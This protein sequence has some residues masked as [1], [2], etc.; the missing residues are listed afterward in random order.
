MR[1][2]TNNDN[3]KKQRRQLLIDG[4]EVKLME[5]MKVEEYHYRGGGVLLM[6]ERRNGRMEVQ[7]L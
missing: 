4:K 7:V 2:V 3:S 5:V 1:G 6:R